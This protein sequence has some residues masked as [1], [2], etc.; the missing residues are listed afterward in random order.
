[1]ARPPGIGSHAWDLLRAR[2]FG[3]YGRAC[4]ICGHAGANQVDHVQSYTEH[5]E[6]AFA[7]S[8][9]RPAHGSGNRCVTCGQCCNQVKAGMSVERARRIIAERMAARPAPK[10]RPAVSASDAGRDWLGRAL[11]R[12][13]PV[14][15]QAGQSSRARFGPGI[16]LLPPQRRHVA[17]GLPPP[18]PPGLHAPGLCGGGS[19][20]FG[21]SHTCRFRLPCGSSPQMCWCPAPLVDQLKP[22][23][24]RLPSLTLLGFLTTLLGQLRR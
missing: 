6:L 13:C 19:K 14:P 2:V 4:W 3:A 23:T 9:M 15:L 10:R 1:M 18:E 7:L 22:H 5:P 8:N 17:A 24:L 21:C 16:F 11:Y 20:Q 12:A